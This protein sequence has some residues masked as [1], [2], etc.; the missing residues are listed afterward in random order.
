M[1]LRL[2]EVFGVRHLRWR[3]HY[4]AVVNMN[5]RCPYLSPEFN[6]YRRH[7]QKFLEKNMIQI[8]E[9]ILKSEREIMKTIKAVLILV[10]AEESDV[11]MK[12]MG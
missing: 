3:L 5:C 12:N 1:D 2:D 8:F 4:G 6:L 10:V 11:S 9:I 7:I